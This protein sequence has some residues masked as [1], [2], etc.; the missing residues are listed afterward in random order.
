MAKKAEPHLNSHGRRGHLT[1]WS[2]DHGTFGGSVLQLHN[3]SYMIWLNFLLRA[4][5][6][7][8]AS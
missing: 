4:M 8:I 3:T 7:V 2:P 5:L 1:T 6:H